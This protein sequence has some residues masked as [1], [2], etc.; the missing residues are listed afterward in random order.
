VRRHLPDLHTLR[1]RFETDDVP[2]SASAIAFQV[3]YALIPILLV[4]L[5]ALGFLD[6]ESVWRDAAE[7]IRPDLS[8]PAFEVVDDTVTHVLSSKQPFWLT[9]GALL[10]IWRLSAAM[11][12]VMAALDRIYDA[13]RERP[14][15][16][17]LRVS[18]AL[19]LAVA[20]LLIGAVAAI[21]L[22][23]LVLPDDGA[24]LSVMSTAL[25][26]GVAG[27]L[28]LLAVGLTIHYGPAT[29]Q[30]LGWVSFGTLVCVG[31]WLVASAAFGFYAT[32][33]ADYGSVFGAF[34]TLFI[35]LTYLYLSA[36]ALL[37]GAAVD[38]QVRRDVSGNR[39]GA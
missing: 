3:L 29:P 21:R 24:A 32:R 13:R 10:A 20:A 12:A 27:L 39:A 33:I 34:A 26:W 37:T 8:R 22:G 11:R 19:S 35:L 9:G 17:Q 31:L 4:L 23:A 28:L 7:D 36:T 6:L 2:G 1:R 15:G 18:V 25:R 30:P 16:E 14:L 38:A 5:A